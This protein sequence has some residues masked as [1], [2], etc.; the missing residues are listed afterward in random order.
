MSKELEIIG[1]GGELA[2]ASMAHSLRRFTPLVEI[3]GIARMIV[4]SGIYPQWKTP[5]ALCV[6]MMLCE[7]SGQHPI[8]VL[9]EFDCIQGR[10]A[11]KSI[12]MLSR[13]RASG[14]RI[15]W[16]AATD[17]CVSGTFVARDGSSITVSWT[18]ARAQKAGLTGK[19][20]WKHYPQQMLRARCQA[21]AIR[22]IAPEVLMGHYTVEEVQDMP[23]LAVASVS[24]SLDPP[25]IAPPA[26]NRA[27]APA[28][29]PTPDDNRLLNAAIRLFGVKAIELGYQDIHITNGIKM[30]QFAINVSPA[31]ANATE[32]VWRNPETWKTLKDNL[33]PPI[34]AEI[35]N[36]EAGSLLDVEPVAVSAQAQG[37]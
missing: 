16:D 23:P 11:R 20:N 32:D 8:Q 7:A 15:Q 25:R 9:E 10:P 35:D 12:A 13:F 29:E 22:A 2:P 30:R 14:G 31:H 21:E 28:S 36:S 34:Y 18:M 4:S 5:E 1:S 6:L 3:D 33:E 24:T 19:D 27:P 26:S 17:D 37:L